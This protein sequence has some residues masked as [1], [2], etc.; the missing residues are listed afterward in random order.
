MENKNFNNVI[1]PN[2][3]DSLSET[4]LIYLLLVFPS[5][6]FLLGSVLVC[7]MFLGMHPFLPTYP[8]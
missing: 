3:F 4:D 2:P 6:Q 1:S 5:L 7:C 8:I